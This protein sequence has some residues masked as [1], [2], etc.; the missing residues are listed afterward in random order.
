MKIA[1]SINEVLR[2]FIGQLAY[3]Y[4]KYINEIDIKENDVTN[5]NL[6]EFFKF[7]TVDDLNKFLYL[8]APLEI[9]GH[10]DQLSDG[11]MNH[12]NN[13]LMDIEDEEE[14]EIELVSKEANKS[15]PSTFF[16]L[17]KTGCRINKIR[18]VK[19]STKE[20]DGVDVLI[21]ANPDALMSKP[22]NKLSIKIKTSYN[23]DIKADFE[24]DSIL[25]FIKD[26]NLRNK[27]LNTKIT[28]YEEI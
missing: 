28:T 13:F 3:T 19:D 21:T 10:A 1:I 8:E 20:W 5:F 11:L 23:Q 18:F 15:I 27:I 7:N 26:E 17:S 24:L 4:N 12:F 2:D 25:E 9:F 14:H 16:F 22:S 6:I